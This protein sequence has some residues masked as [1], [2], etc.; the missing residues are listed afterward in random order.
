VNDVIII[1]GT[2]LRH[3]ATSRNVAGSIPDD[4]IGN[5]HLYFPSGRTMALVWT[6]TL[7]GMSTRNI[8]WGVKAAGV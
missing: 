8:F 5:F 2:R 7:T 1:G 6:Q 3:C 4:V